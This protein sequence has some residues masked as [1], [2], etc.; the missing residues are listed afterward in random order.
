M[1]STWQDVWTAKATLQEIVW[2]G[3]GMSPLEIS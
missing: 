3:V 2:D 1:S